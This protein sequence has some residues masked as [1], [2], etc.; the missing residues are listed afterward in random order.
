MGCSTSLLVDTSKFISVQ[1]ESEPTNKPSEP[2]TKDQKQAIRSCWEVMAINKENMAR[3]IYLRVFERRPEVKDL[4]AFRE[5]W[6][7]ELIT[8]PE[9]RSHILGFMAAIQKGV[10]DL[11]NLDLTYAPFLQRLG[12]KHTR[13]SGFNAENFSEFENAILHILRREL[14]NEYNMEKEEAWKLFL[15]YIIDTMCEGYDERKKDD[16]INETGN[17]KTS[18]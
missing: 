9:F 6:G 14:S 16:N 8:D 2:L 13:T 17:L 5:A 7:D 18:K 15:K 10:E 12:A 11:D 1:P 3:Q 4:F